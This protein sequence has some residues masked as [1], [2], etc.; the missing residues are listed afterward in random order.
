ML[1]GLKHNNSLNKYLASLYILFFILSLIPTLPISTSLYVDKAGEGN[2]GYVKS[3]EFDFRTTKFFPATVSVLK[4]ATI[5]RKISFVSVV[6]INKY[7]I[8]VQEIKVS[9]GRSIYYNYYLVILSTLG[10]TIANR[11]LIKEGLNEYNFRILYTEKYTMAVYAEYGPVLAYVH[12]LDKDVPRVYEN[13][14]SNGEI[15]E[16]GFVY[17]DY[18]VVFTDEK[19]YVLYDIYRLSCDRMGEGAVLNVYVVN[20]MLF[21]VVAT[22]AVKGYNVRIEVYSIDPPL[23]SPSFKLNLGTFKYPTR[24]TVGFT[25]DGFIVVNDLNNTVYKYLFKNLLVP[26]EN[27]TLSPT[28]Y[29]LFSA[30]V[31]GIVVVIYQIDRTVYIETFDSE[32]R[33]I[34]KQLLPSALLPLIYAHTYK[35]YGVYNGPESEYILLVF[36]RLDPKSEVSDFN[37]L[38]IDKGYGVTNC[39]S[40][41]SKNNLIN[42]YMVIHNGLLLAFDAEF[43]PSMY[44]AR[45]RY[46][47]LSTIDCTYFKPVGPI[48]AVYTPVY[49]NGQTIIPFIDSSGS[50]KFLS[51]KDV[52]VAIANGIPCILTYRDEKGQSFTYTI[53]NPPFIFTIKAGKINIRCVSLKGYTG[54][55]DLY[56]FEPFN[57]PENKIYYINTT[58]FS[59]HLIV[60]GNAATLVLQDSS[61]LYPAFILEHTGGKSEYYLPP[62]VFIVK[63][64]RGST[65][66]GETTLVLDKSKTVVLD[67]DVVESQGGSKGPLN[68]VIEFISQN[69]SLILIA[70][71][72][73]VIAIFILN[74][75]FA[76]PESE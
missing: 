75:V 41:S 49:I 74:M 1:R 54:A 23:L 19:V 21:A 71:I 70:V 18:I 29:I 9:G 39:Y 14:L 48:K 60:K 73:I 22:T 31:N 4:R 16:R 63:I 7:V 32:L 2:I 12:D 56:P 45:K 57:I 72:A 20:K 26:A 30:V 3:R 15:V 13:V 62:G 42:S 35:N 24:Y 10:R 43:Q 8:G 59:S 52:S 33:E 5:T 46:L 76:R 27:V 68:D 44:K 67:I 51:I 28:A 53:D 61:Y 50:L 66:V 58:S 38:I 36:S 37:L 69:I 25:S 6:L 64:L 34:N 47:I 65:V 40:F 17:E 11:T 55:Y